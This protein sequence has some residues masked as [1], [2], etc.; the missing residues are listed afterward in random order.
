MSA[1]YITG[2]PPLWTSGS[3]A[4]SSTRMNWKTLFRFD[5]RSSAS[6]GG[7]AVVP[8]AIHP[9]TRMKRPRR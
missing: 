7:V 1:R 6:W 3:Y 5:Q 8:L 9:G 2:F 4:V